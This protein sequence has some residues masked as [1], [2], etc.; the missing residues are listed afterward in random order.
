MND[1]VLESLRILVLLGLVIF[2]WRA[3]RGRAGLVQ[4]GWGFLLAGLGLLLFGSTLDISNNY[5]SLNR[6]IIIG[7]TEISAF[8][9]KYVGYLGGFILLALGLIRWTPAVQRL[10]DEVVERRVSQ[11]RL[12]D[13]GSWYAMA[14]S[15][16]K[17]GHWHFDEI[18][19]VYLDI[20]D[21]Y[22]AVFG[23]S[24]EEFLEGF[25]TYEDDLKLVHPDD[26]EKVE[27]AYTLNMDY[28]EIDY[29][30]LH[31]DGEYRHVREISRHILDES[32]EL[33]EAMGTLQ[34]VTELKL[35]QIESERANRAK[36]DFL[37]RM[38][39]ELRTP[40]NAIIGFTQL[41]E[42]DSGLDD[43]QQK[44]LGHVASAANHLLTL[45][46][47]MLDLESLESG[48][49]TLDLEAVDTGEVLQ[50]CERLVRPLAEKHEISIDRQVLANKATTVIADK[51]RLKQVVLNLMSNAVKYNREGGQVLLKSE[52]FG[53]GVLRVSVTDTGPG[54]SE[55]NMEKLFEPF[56]RL[57]AEKSEIE[58]TGIGLTITKRLA[59]LMDGK[60][61]VETTFGEGSTFW[62][63]LP[64]G[65]NQN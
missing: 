61:G 60:I 38:S 58:G 47:E 19:D 17:L 43:K 8:L 64:T 18:E 51:T 48:K 56:S 7:D 13:R 57:G 31:A 21:E 46:N 26:V 1:T 65:L 6:F 16:A 20:S 3:G 34:D 52:D 53:N 23:Y 63:E 37:S 29:R 30:I 55:K 25:G 2:L 50:E 39:H 59:E 22:A 15:T 49:I 54:L 24:V 33:I 5:P 62:F 9:E 11:R 4:Q 40:M 10:S 45:I 44:Y 12:T 36:S 42:M 35:A 41:L 28:M 27:K 32:G 14:A